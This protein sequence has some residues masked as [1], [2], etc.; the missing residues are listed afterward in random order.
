MTMENMEKLPHRSIML[1]MIIIV[2]QILM[3]IINS[4]QQKKSNTKMQIH[5]LNYVSLPIIFKDKNW[6]INKKD[7]M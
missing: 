6:L 1:R 3:R 7:S 2:M 4:Q 5:S